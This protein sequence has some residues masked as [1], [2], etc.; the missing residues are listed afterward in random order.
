MKYTY[1]LNLETRL[2]RTGLF[3]IRKDVLLPWKKLPHVE[4]VSKLDCY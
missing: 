1:L 3:G 4:N 2:E